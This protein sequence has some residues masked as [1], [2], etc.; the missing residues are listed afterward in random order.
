MARHLPA[1]SS[2]AYFESL[3]FTKNEG[4]EDSRTEFLYKEIFVIF[5]SSWCTGV[6]DRQRRH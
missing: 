3:F 2:D 4:H 1:L 6:A 5:V